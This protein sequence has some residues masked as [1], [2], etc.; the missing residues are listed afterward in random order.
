MKKLIVMTALILAAVLAGAQNISEVTGGIF[1]QEGIASW[2]GAEFSGRPTSSGEIFNPSLFTAAHP[3]LPFGTMLKITNTHNNKSVTVK[4]NDRG[5]FVA[6]RIIDLSQ[7]AAEVL[8]MIRTGTAP[9][10]VESIGEVALPAKKIPAASAAP[11]VSSG[12]VQGTAIVLPEPSA[13]WMNIAP[14]DAVQ[15]QTGSVQPFGADAPESMLK[16]PVLPDGIAPVTGPA[17]HSGAQLKGQAAAGKKYS[18]QVGAYKQP[19]N[20]VEVY[21][22]LK[23]LGLDPAYEKYGDYYRVV[24]SSIKGEEVPAVKEKLSGA[25]IGEAIL[26]EEP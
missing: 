11:A 18:I 16:M 12:G 19:R 3:L 6:A 14:G 22:K 21:E 24:L 17:M 10:I 15:V 25:G 13:A 23:G 4:V 9:V 7:A 26:R 1:R 20:A 2:Y 5:P 8:D